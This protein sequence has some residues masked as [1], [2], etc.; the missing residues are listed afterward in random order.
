MTRNRI[1]LLLQSALCIVLVVMLASAAVG[2]YRT[3]I[4]EK[5]ENP[6]AWVYTREKVAA[7]LKPVAP[8]FLLAVAVTVTCSVLGVRDE[9]QDKP[10]KD[11]E[12]TRDLLVSRVAEPSEA[13]KKE[14]ALQKKWL[15]GGWGLF[16]LC[17]I[18]VLVYMTDAGH[19]LNGDLEEMIKSLASHALLWTALGLACLIVSTLQQ[20]KSMQRECD[21]ASARIREEKAA[22]ISP[23]P[24]EKPQQKNLNAVRL[25]ILAVAVVFILLG[26]RN[27]SM[28]AVINKAIRICTECVGLG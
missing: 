28:T 6:L 12:L 17:M 5:Q 27:G 16:A 22:G 13:M 21:L 14:Q 9:R 18:P 10:V 19:F 1:L 2:I 4:A 11:V 23:A 3:G 25:V 24:T 7:A 26:I 15:F 8:V 20:E